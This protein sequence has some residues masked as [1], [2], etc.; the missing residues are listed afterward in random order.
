MRGAAALT[1][2][3]CVLVCADP[4]AY[5]QTSDQSRFQVA[6]GLTWTGSYPIGESSAD[7]IQ[8]SPGATPP[9]LTLFRTSSTFESSPGVEARFGVAITPRLMIEVGGAYSKPKVLVDILQDTETTATSFDGETVSQY[10]VDVSLVWE[11]PVPSTAR[12]RPYAIGGG[13]YLRQL[14]EDD[15]LVETGQLYH[16]GGG[17]R[18]FFHGAATGHPFGIRGDVQAAFRRDG[19]EF[20][21]QRRVMPTVSVLVFFGF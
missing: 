2:A 6:G 5:A 17:A 16:F 18:V 21:D 15:A 19:I 14:H 20:E 4:R 7:L 9:A 1:I 13:G 10:I 8:N 11:V 3:A 12:V